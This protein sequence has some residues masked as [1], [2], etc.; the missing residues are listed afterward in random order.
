ML[1]LLPPSETKAAGGEMD[2]ID[3]SFPALDPIRSEILDDL[4]VLDVDKMMATLKIPT[5]KRR[6]AEEN[7]SLRHA[8]VMPAIYRYTGVLYDALS[9]HTLPDP[10]LSRIAIGSALFG[11]VR[12]NDSIPRYRLSGA[13]KLPARDGSLPTMKTRWGASISDVLLEAG[14]VI[15]MRS[16][17]YHT[18]GPV[19]GATTVRVETE[20]NGTR[21]VI[22]HFNKHYKGELARALALGPTCTSIDEVATAAHEAGFHVEIAD[23]QL[24]LVV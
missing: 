24:T 8:P 3:V 23:T 9:A 18:L 20:S 6:E 1:I 11:V 16:G 13:S 7:R 21:K 14:F 17:A 15:D 4:A 2:G 5:S 12:A 19:P 10:A 22:S